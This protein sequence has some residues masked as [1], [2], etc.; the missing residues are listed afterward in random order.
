MLH[1]RI[2]DI[3]DA[4]ISFFRISIRSRFFCVDRSHVGIYKATCHCEI[5]LL[6]LAQINCVRIVQDN[7]CCQN[8][9]MR[10]ASKGG[11][12]SG[13]VSNVISFRIAFLLLLPLLPCDF[14]PVIA[15]CVSR[16]IL[17][18]IHG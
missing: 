3:V 5:V 13:T 6:I 4:Q 12:I 7:V 14:Q 8:S 1:L 18:C 15:T 10:S 11:I 9:T 2:Y 16:C 17:R